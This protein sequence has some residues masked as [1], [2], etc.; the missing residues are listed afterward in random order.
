MESQ[1]F[2]FFNL[3]ARLSQQEQGQDQEGR[4]LV[5]QFLGVLL[6]SDVLFGHQLAAQ[7]EENSCCDD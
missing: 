7:V 3:V 4:V 6:V 1:R 2:D 5:P